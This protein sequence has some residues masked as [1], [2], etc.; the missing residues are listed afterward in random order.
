VLHVLSISSFKSFRFM[1]QPVFKATVGSFYVL[2]GRC[3]TQWPTAEYLIPLGR[4]GMCLWVCGGFPPNSLYPHPP[5]GRLFR[6]TGR[7]TLYTVNATA[8]MLHLL[9]MLKSRGSAVGIATGWT[10]EES[11]IFT[12]PCRPD[13]FWGPPSHLSSGYRGLFSS[14]ELGGSLIAHQL[15]PSA[16]LSASLNQ[17]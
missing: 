14:T 4:N 5:T 8:R 1:S 11:R 16:N 17:D 2:N 7:L 6:R 3:A 10:T 12:S 13:R 15:P 9:R